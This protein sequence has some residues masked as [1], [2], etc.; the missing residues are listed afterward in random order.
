MSDETHEAVHR[1]EAPTSFIRK[2]IFSLDHK[3]IG[4]QY[5]IL[6]L[7]A[8]IVGMTMSLLMRMNLS[9]P[10]T[11][12]PILATLFPGGAPGGVINP[13]F[14]LSLVTMHGTIMVFFVLTTA[15]QGGF[16]NYFLPIQIGAEDMAFPVLNMLSFWVTFVG[17]IVILSAIFFSGSAS[18]I[19][20][21]GGW[22]GYAP[23]SALGQI[24]GPGQ[25]M[26]MNL[27]IISIAIF[28][29]GSLLGALNFIT[30]L[31]NMRTRG[32]SLMRMPLTCWAWFTTA[33]L[34]LLSFPVLLGGG[35]L[36]LLDRVA[37]TSFFIPG[38]LYVSGILS[39]TTPSFPIHT[40]GSPILW[41]HL[42][43]FF[44]HPEVYIAILPGMGATS[45]ILSTFARKPVFGYRAMVFAIFAIGLLGFFVW[46]HHM[47][48]S[49]MSPYSAM[50]FSILTLSIGVPSAVKTFNWLGTLWGA[51][52]R[53]TTPMLFALGFVSL[54]VA[55]GITGLVLG[56]TSLDLPM[57]DTY[58]VLAHFHLVMGVAS[59]FGMFAATYFWF[60]KMFGRFMND[61]LG[62]IHFWITFVGVYCIF[63][64]MHV[65]GLVGMPRRYAQFTEYTFLSRL[66]PL[67]VFVSIV[68]IITVLTQFLFYFNLIWSIFKGKKAGAN[69]WD[70]TTLE[71]T[72]A[73][74]PPHDN[75]AGVLPVVYRGPYEF[76]VPG[77]PNDF[78]MQTE[79][80]T[81]AERV[82][83][84]GHNGHRH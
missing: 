84:N 43:W 6:A 23:L 63:V 46:G 5:I 8:V 22:T 24:A 41:Q 72:T 52:I 12:W 36:L 14:Y 83:G 80:E 33:V 55:G 67:V 20:P 79:P 31:L 47:F 42:F 66:H 56:Q 4:I 34:A 19:G 26:G 15:P 9:W 2:Y 25:G 21:I 65:M 11:N 29:V 35:I 27:W 70:A 28:C 78:V 32:M 16:G 18:T 51:R 69:P 74:P 10:G 53:F 1:H 44:G 13:E 39:G 38:G 71:W 75:F 64:P 62:R 57:H 60:P 50:T 68:A 17:F 30:T 82:G 54:F 81:E 45:H 76:A 48:I 3:V 7:V 37:G 73:S 40:G 49:G 59:I 61:T 58:F 77:A